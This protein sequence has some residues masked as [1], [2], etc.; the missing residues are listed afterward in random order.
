MISSKYLSLQIKIKI[1]NKINSTKKCNHK[2]KGHHL[3]SLQE[4]SLTNIFFINAVYLVPV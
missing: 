4:Y 3:L 1:K 2:E